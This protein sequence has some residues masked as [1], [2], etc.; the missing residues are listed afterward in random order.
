MAAESSEQPGGQEREN[1]GGKRRDSCAVAPIECI[2]VDSIDLKAAS[3]EE[4]S[5]RA[6]V[7]HEAS[8]LHGPFLTPAAASGSL[9]R[10]AELRACSSDELEAKIAAELGLD[11]D[12]DDGELVNL[13]LVDAEELDAVL[14]ED[15]SETEG[16]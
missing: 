14:A 15:D 11:D 12:D 8:M 6:G 2:G 10:S 1:G 3:A 9:D 13:E 5:A 7:L 4:P 16:P